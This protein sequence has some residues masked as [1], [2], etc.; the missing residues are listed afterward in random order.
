VATYSVPAEYYRNVFHPIAPLRLAAIALA[1]TTGVGILLAIRRRQPTF[2]QPEL[3]TGLS[4]VGTSMAAYLVEYF[5]TDSIPLRLSYVVIA[6]VAVA[7]TIGLRAVHQRMLPAALVL[8]IVIDLS[9]LRQLAAEPIRI[10]HL[11]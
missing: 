7:A 6:Y 11:W 10:F 9:F 4:V 3:L 5:S 2:R 8:L 1:F